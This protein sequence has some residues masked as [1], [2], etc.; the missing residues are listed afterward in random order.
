LE[1]HDHPIPYPL[2][3]V[4]KDENIKAIK[5]C[6]IKFSTSVDFIDEVELDA[7]PLDMCGVVF[8]IPYMYMM[9]VIFIQR[10][11][12]YFLI[13]DGKSHIINTQKGKSNISLV[14]A[15]K[16]KKLFISSEKYVFLFL[17]ETQPGEELIRVKASLE[18]C[19]KE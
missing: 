3:W 18:G 13:K 16:D 14:S 5:Q 9:D 2:V 12:Q 15:N 7:V 8:G 11:N 19:T 6:K 10:D 17:R 4:N 1:V